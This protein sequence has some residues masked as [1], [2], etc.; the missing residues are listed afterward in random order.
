MAVHPFRFIASMPGPGSDIGAW[1][2]RVRD[3]EAMGYG[4]VAIS[5]HLIGAWSMDPW[6]RMTAAV[7]ATT[8]LRVMTLVLAND[9]RHPALVH[10]AIAE[11]DRIS[12]GRV[13]LGLGTGWW[14]D[15]YAAMGIQLDPPTLRVER[16]AEAIA[17]IKGLFG[18]G[19][20]SVAGAHYQVRDMVG[21]PPPT[22]LPW[23]PILVGGG[24]R[25]MLELAGREADIAGIFPPRGPGGLVPVTALEEERM[26]ERVATIAAAS[27]A[28]GRAPGLPRLQVSLL[29]WDLRSPRGRSSGNSSVGSSEL[30]AAAALRDLVG[31]L[32]GDVDE[33]CG[34]LEAWRR[35]HGVS[36]IHVG[37]DA[38]AFAPIVERLAGR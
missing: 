17:V 2:D 8:R 5:D 18:A 36:E 15:E 34:R 7:L 33:A 6:V 12:G 23:P 25:P 22:Q 30:A 35:V 10:R 4:A 13:E 9:Y 19:P 37:S 32:V 28:E 24:A 3:I 21:A 31:V 1:Q 27:R 26:A 14:A 29:A 16:L 38:L 11:L 20:V